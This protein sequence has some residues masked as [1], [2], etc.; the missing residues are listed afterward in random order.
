L[1]LRNLALMNAALRTR[2]LWLQRTS[3]DKPWAGLPIA[4]AESTVSLF[5]ASVSI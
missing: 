4:A 1:G 3:M 2:W 5:N